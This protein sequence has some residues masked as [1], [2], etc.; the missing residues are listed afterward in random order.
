MNNMDNA[1]GGRAA[2]FVN[3]KLKYDHLIRLQFTTGTYGIFS[4]P[5]P[6]VLS[7]ATSKQETCEIAGHKLVNG[8]EFSS[9]ST[10]VSQIFRYFFN[11][12]RFKFKTLT[13]FIFKVA[14][15]ISV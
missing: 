2:I 1:L 4:Y 5:P 6:T 3:Q 10:V 8:S 15:T 13:F 11:I 14:F 7:L 9:N 12:K